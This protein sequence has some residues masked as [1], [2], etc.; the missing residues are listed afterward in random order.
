MDLQIDEK[1][2]SY[3][4]PREKHHGATEN[5]SKGNVSYRVHTVSVQIKCP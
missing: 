4:T 1:S 5:H 3:S 2:Q